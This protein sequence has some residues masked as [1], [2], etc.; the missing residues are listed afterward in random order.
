MIRNRTKLR[1]YRID[2]IDSIDVHVQGQQPG[3]FHDHSQCSRT[4]LDLVWFLFIIST[5]SVI[6]AIQVQR[7]DRIHWRIV[8]GWPA[9]TYLHDARDFNCKSISLLCSQPPSACHL[10][11]IRNK[12]DRR[13]CSHATFPETVLI[14]DVLETCSVVARENP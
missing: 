8:I 2:H 12:E 1:S 14:S 4:T 6:G 5:R 10:S 7:N 9:A 13:E 11:S 3:R